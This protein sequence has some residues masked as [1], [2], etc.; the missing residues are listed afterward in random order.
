M[1]RGSPPD[2]QA[3]YRSKAPGMP[4]AHPTVDHYVPLFITLGTADRVGEPA[5]TMIDGY[6][7]GLAK[8]SFQTS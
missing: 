7:Y 5:R 6:A 2:R 1:P 4:Y 8:R 3:A